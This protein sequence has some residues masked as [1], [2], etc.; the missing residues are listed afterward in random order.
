MS[1]IDRGLSNLW[2]RVDYSYH[3]LHVV[4][5]VLC[6]CEKISI[7]LNTEELIIPTGL[8]GRG[9]AIQVVSGPVE[10]A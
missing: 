7:H 5:L 9:S 4:L 6:I 2:V 3:L 10:G 8:V 1:E